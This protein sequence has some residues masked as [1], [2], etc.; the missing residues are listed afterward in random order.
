MMNRQQLVRSFLPL[1][2]LL[3]ACGATYDPPSLIVPDKVRILGIRAEPAAIT[4][5]TETTMTVLT[6]GEQTGATLCYAWAYCPYTWTKDGAYSCIDDSLMVPLSTDATAQVGIA[7]VFASLAQA[8]AVFTKLGLQMPSSGGSSS[9]DACKPA[10]GGG[11]PLASAALPDSYILFQVAQSDLFGGKC[12][13][14]HTA[15]SAP[16]TDR[17]K[18]IQGFKR[19]TVNAAT[20]TTCAAFD[21]A[22]DKNC[23]KADACDTKQ[24]CGCDDRTYDTECDRVAAKVSKKSDGACPDQNPSISGISVHWPLSSGALEVLGTM[25]GDT[26][27]YKVDAKYTGLVAWPED[28]TITV[29]PGDS[30]EMLPLWPGAAKEYVGK[31]TDPAAPP[32]YETLLFS[33]F[34][35]GG[36]WAKDRSYDEYP[37]NVFT[38]PDL[39]AD[40]QPVPLTLWIV[41]R[42]G[43]NGTAWVERHVT[44]TKSVGDPLD[45]LHPLCRTTP[46]LPGCPAK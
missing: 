44:V 4:M 36:A 31:S 8:P 15:F 3:A 7:D 1:L 40:G 38:A 21:A 39:N 14:I 22:T 41:V 17:G 16:C 24:V 42:D 33:W 30:F 35:T 2:A 28:V 9:A 25:Q 11:N 18:C 43:R 10:A 13:D 20:P 12:P 37:E 26:H 34:T 27:T 6:A 29:H 5:T 32:V 19:L 46:P 45:Q 23:S